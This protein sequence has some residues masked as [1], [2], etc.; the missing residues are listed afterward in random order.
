[1]QGEGATV[2]RFKVLLPAL[3]DTTREHELNLRDLCQV[4]LLIADYTDDVLLAALTE[5]EVGTFLIRA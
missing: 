1:M 2:A 5:G 4:V 3:V